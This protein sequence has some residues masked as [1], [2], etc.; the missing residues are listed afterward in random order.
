MQ[1]LTA[2]NL[3]K[4][5]KL[6]KREITVLEDVS[7]SITQG[8]FT[9]IQGSSGSGKTTLLSLLSGLDRPTTGQVTIAP[10]RKSHN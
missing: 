2:A 1:I 7:L 9:V 3:S 4:S 5:Y 6:E 8:E 10:A